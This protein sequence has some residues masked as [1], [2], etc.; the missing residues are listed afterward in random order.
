MSFLLQWFFRAGSKYGGSTSAACRYNQFNRHVVSDSGYFCD[1][2]G[3]VLVLH[4]SP[5]MANKFTV[6]E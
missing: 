6:G 3:R 5:N 2:P 1:P 4:G